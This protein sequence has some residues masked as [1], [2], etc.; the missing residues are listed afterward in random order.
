[1]IGNWQKEQNSLRGKEQ[2][3]ASESDII[4]PFLFIFLIPIYLFCN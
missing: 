1:M 3:K 4:T 2:E